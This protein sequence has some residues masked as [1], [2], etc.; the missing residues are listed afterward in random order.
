MTKQRV[1]DYIAQFVA[2][3]VKDVF[4]LSGGGIMFLTDGIVCNPDLNP[5]CFLHEQAASMAMD[6]YSRVTENFAVG[7]FTT[8]PG[9]TN[10]I[11]GLAG[12]WLDSV[13]CMFISGQVKQKDTLSNAGID[14]IRQIGVQEID[15]IP[16]VKSLTKYAVMI[17]DPMHIRYH[18]EKAVW[19]SKEGRPGPVWIDIPLDIQ[20]AYIDILAMEGFKPPVIKDATMD[21]AF[22]R[23][24]QNI[25]LTK[26]ILSS[27][28]PVILAGHGVRLAGSIEQLLTFAKVS[29]IPIVT[30]YL[31]VDLIDTQS[32]NYIGRVGIK[33]DR[34]G[35]LAVQNADL[36][37]VIGASLPVAETGYDINQFAP[38]AN[39]II[40]DIDCSSH[41]KNMRTVPTL[42][43]CDAKVFLYEL[44]NIIEKNKI[45]Y[46]TWLARCISWREKY[47]S[48]LPEYADRRDKVSIHYFI[49]KLCRKLDSTDI[50]VTETGSASF[51]GSQSVHIKQ[52]MRYIVSG[53]LSTMGFSIPA[54]IGASIATGNK[55]VICITGDGS[56]QLNFQ[57]LQTII[58]YNLPVKIFVINNEGYLTIR[59]TQKKLFNGRFIGEGKTSG[60]TFPDL[61]GIATA[62]KIPFYKI[63]NNV[64]MDQTIDMVLQCSGPVI[65]EVMT[66]PDQDITPTTS[67]MKMSDGTMISKPIEDMYPFIPRKEFE[68]SMNMRDS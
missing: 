37:I 44:S 47:P 17:T 7:Y 49:N 60:V 68:D 32:P 50:I 6:A 25:I 4:M 29:N 18:L 15:I 11:T 35:N 42:F 39:I 45:Q 56:F 10:T 48:C 66:P 36:L 13:P 64:Q 54:S 12:A 23:Y 19:I 55:R 5:I 3:Q 67:S 38:K 2:K 59:T 61:V 8:G 51:A 58:H 46:P 30:T 33:G 52:G 1:S 57:E 53:G 65:C 22:I 9:A 20:S 43:E 16:I 28:R 41:R 14:G 27:H 24:H 34:A 63:S 26:L 40:N 62:Y 21:F 31:G